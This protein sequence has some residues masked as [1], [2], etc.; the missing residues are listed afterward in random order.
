MRIRVLHFPNGPEVHL[1]PLTVLIGPNNAGKSRM[2]RGIQASFGDPQQFDVVRADLEPR[3][4]YETLDDLGAKQ[5]GENW[6]YELRG[7]EHRLSMKHLAATVALGHYDN[8]MQSGAIMG[9][10]VQ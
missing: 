8:F 1:A 2:L 6:V 9:S 10:K 3:N 4:L 5:R 7:F